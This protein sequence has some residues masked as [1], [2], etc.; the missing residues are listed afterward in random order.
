MYCVGNLITTDAGRS[1]AVEGHSTSP[2]Q[3]GKRRSTPLPSFPANICR[4]SNWVWT[5]LSYCRKMPKGPHSWVF[6][7]SMPEWWNS[8]PPLS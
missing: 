2:A 5:R 4:P 7:S 8:H 6:R 3:K 1:P